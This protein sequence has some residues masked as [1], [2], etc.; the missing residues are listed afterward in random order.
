[1]EKYVVVKV[2]EPVEL[3]K[4]GK[5]IAASDG[6][7]YIRNWRNTGKVR[8]VKQYIGKNGYLQ[9]GFCPKS[10]S[11]TTLAHRFIAKCFIPNPDNLPQINHKNEIK[12]DNRVENLEWCTAKYNANYGSGIEK[13]RNQKKRKSVL[14]FT[15]DGKLVAEYQS[16]G[17]V[18]RLTG[19]NR[20][21]IT[22][23]CHGKI[24]TAYGFVWRFAE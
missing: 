7:I 4:C 2:G 21:N 10:K 6:K 3:V 20:Q 22:T 8:E 13:R 15:K 9:F 24:K 18:E 16:G 23:C 12:K 11:I 19:F 5:Y 14:Q 1:M 17:E